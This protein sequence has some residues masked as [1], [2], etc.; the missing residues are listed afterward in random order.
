MMIYRILIALVFASA[1]VAWDVRAWQP[2]TQECSRV[3]GAILIMECESAG[4]V[5][6]DT[7]SGALRVSVD[8]QAQAVGN[9]PNFWAGLALNGD[10]VGD[11]QY[12]EVAVTQGI[13]PFEDTGSPTA[14]TLSTTGRDDCCIQMQQVDAAQWHTLVID[15]SNGRATYTVDGRSAT[16]KVNPGRSYQIEL[17]C[18]ATNPGTASPGALTRCQWRNLTT[19]GRQPRSRSP[20]RG[21]ELSRLG[22][23][24]RIPL[25]A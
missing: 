1:P 3:E 23:D 9:S 25:Q 19:E 5:S 16:V 7:Y 13:Q 14:V 8:V 17:L 20:G 10:V 12:A 4:L 21:R 18:V 24:K 6:K 2:I 11:S 22:R 15:Y